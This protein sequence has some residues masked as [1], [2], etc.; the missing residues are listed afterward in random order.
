LTVDVEVSTVDSFQ[1]REKDCIILSL[2]RSNDK[3]NVGFLSQKKR[4]NV[5][6]TRTKKF[7]V[8]IGN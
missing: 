3:G 4:L 8:L 7:L 6:I 1:G 2:V 5:A